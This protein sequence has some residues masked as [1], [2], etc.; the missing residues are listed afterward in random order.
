MLDPEHVESLGVDQLGVETVVGLVLVEDVAKRVPVGGALHTQHQ[1]I[2]GV[3]NLVPILPLGDSVGAGR[4]H[5]MN[6]IEAPP[7]KTGLRTVGIERYAKSKHL[8]AADEVCSL[9]DVLRTNV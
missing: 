9:D 1:R 8:A 2:V 7:K 3:T 4:E 5:L 6:R